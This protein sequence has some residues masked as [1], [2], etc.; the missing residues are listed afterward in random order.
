M[1]E[2]VVWAQADVLTVRT[3]L[4]PD[5][6]AGALETMLL[7]AIRAGADRADDLCDVFGLAPRL[8]EGILGDLW[9]AGRISIAL[10]T[11]QEQ[12]T[13]TSSGR[14]RLDDLDESSS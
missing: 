13:P 6:R 10:G 8:I 9:R 5:D 7:K 14:P 3:T 1:S 2:V 12:I 4:V 11:P